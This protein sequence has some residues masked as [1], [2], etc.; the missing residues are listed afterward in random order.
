MGLDPHGLGTGL[1][2][3]PHRAGDP[4]ALGHWNITPFQTP[5]ASVVTATALIGGTQRREEYNKNICGSLLATLH[6]VVPK[7]TQHSAK[8]RS[9]ELGLRRAPRY[10]SAGM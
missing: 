7:R 4:L 10:Q 2:P 1:L 8:L 9:C 3:G 5:A 6:I